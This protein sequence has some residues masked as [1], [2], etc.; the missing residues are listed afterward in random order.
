LGLCA[1]SAEQLGAGDSEEARVVV[2]LGNFSS[3]ALSSID[4]PHRLAGSEDQ[5]SHLWA[6]LSGFADSVG[7]DGSASA[8]GFVAFYRPSVRFANKARGPYQITQRMPSEDG[9]FR[10]RIKGSNESHERV[11]NESE[12]TGA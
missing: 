1:Q 3:P 12:L 4:H 8:K 10:Y 6:E 5:S 9:E 7:H 2:A 11:A